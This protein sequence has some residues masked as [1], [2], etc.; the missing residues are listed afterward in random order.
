METGE[1]RRGL[2]L[3]KVVGACPLGNRAAKRPRAGPAQGDVRP[4]HAVGGLS[5]SPS[6][7]LQRTARLR[8]S[9]TAFAWK[10]RVRLVDGPSPH[11]GGTY[12]GR[13]RSAAPGG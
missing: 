3:V 9:Q 4:L 5:G 12:P 1:S 7:R 6:E 2:R 13:G 8:I 11:G 10:G